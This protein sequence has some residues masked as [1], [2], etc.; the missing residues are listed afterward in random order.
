VATGRSVGEIQ[1]ALTEKLEKFIP[2]LVV[3]VMV[4]NVDGNKIYVIGQVQRPGVF[5][6]NPNVDVMQALSMAGGT[7]PYAALNAIRILRRENGVQSAL[8]FLYG[9]VKK[10]EKL[11]QNIVLRSGDVVVVP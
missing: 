9:E 7:T 3:T 5:V 2:D 8:P 11:E 10:G 4:R 6:V 1:Q